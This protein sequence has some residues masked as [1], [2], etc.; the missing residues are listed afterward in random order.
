MRSRCASVTAVGGASIQLFSALQCQ[1]VPNGRETPIFK[2]DSLKTSSSNL[3]VLVGRRA[4]QASHFLE[5][6]LRLLENR[7]VCEMGWVTSAARIA[8]SGPEPSCK[9]ILLYIS[10]LFLSPREKTR[11]RGEPSHS[12][13]TAEKLVPAGSPPSSCLTFLAVY[14]T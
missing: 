2:Q 6:I 9:A 4:K 7:Q 13:P 10:P 14:L 1:T 11:C 8:E 12:R 3:V 5:T